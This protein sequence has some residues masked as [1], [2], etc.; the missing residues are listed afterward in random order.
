MCRRDKL[1][2]YTGISLP[3][4]LALAL[5]LHLPLLLVLVLGLGGDSRRCLSVAGHQGALP[6]YRSGRPGITASGDRK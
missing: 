6:G 4:A 5:A 2:V 3:P 1:E